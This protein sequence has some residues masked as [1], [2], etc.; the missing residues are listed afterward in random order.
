MLLWAAQVVRLLRYDGL[1]VGEFGLFAMGAPAKVTPRPF[2]H[3]W[4][5]P[6]AVKRA[7]VGSCLASGIVVALEPAPGGAARAADEDG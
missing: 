7:V 2:R 3:D 6:M 1:L 4:N 5:T